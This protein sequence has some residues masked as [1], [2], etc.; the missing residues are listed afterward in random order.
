MIGRLS[1]FID[2]RLVELQ[3]QTCVQQ[4]FETEYQTTLFYWPRYIDERQDNNQQKL[5]QIAGGDVSGI[6]DL[7]K[8]RCERQFYLARRV[9]YIY[10]W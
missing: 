8:L 3:R 5:W 7:F 10:S 2:I 1:S 6:M 4:Q 9:N